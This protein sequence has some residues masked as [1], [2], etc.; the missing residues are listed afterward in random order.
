MSYEDHTKNA[1]R[2]KEKAKAYQDQYIKGTKWARFTMWRQKSIIKRF[3]DLSKVNKDDKV[4]DI[5]CGTGYIGEILAVT[6]AEVFAS[7]ISLE[8]MDLAINEYSSPR[9]SGF[10]QADIT[11]IPFPDESFKAV[12]VLALMH[13]LPREMRAKVLSEIA[14]V[15]NNYVIVSYSVE[16]VSQK[17]KQWLLLKITRSHV[18]AP[19]SIPLPLM[20]GELTAAGFKIIKMRY[21]MYFLSAKVVFLVEK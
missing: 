2:N 4:L 15:S 10:V 9:F 1:Y 12:I 7:D 20:Q 14:R 5:P 11:E 6:E 19:S 16:S 21:I 3:L 13:R 18:P 17:I 8:M